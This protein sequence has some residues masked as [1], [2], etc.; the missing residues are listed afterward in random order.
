M[1]RYQMH[2]MFH[3]LI[4]YVPNIGQEHSTWNILVRRWNQPTNLS[5]HGTV[6][7]DLLTAGTYFMAM[8]ESSWYFT[9]QLVCL[10]Y[11]PHVVICGYSLQYA[12]FFAVS[13]KIHRLMYSVV[14]R[15]RYNRTLC[16][17]SHFDRCESP[18]GRNETFLELVKPG[19]KAT[20]AELLW[21]KLYSELRNLSIYHWK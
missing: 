2:L 13:C 1:I 15:H 3:K 21:W 11:L 9:L 16:D 20:F 4:R 10:K 17:G 5:F 7:N 19:V 8:N 12:Y 14:N 18:S 6:N